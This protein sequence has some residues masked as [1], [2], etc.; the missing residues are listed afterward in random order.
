MSNW[1]AGAGAQVAVA[2]GGGSRQPCTCGE[3]RARL[4]CGGGIGCRSARNRRPTA[5]FCYARQRQ[6][7]QQQ[8]RLAGFQQELSCRASRRRKETASSFSFQ[9]HDV[10][11][12][13]GVAR[14]NSG[15]RG[16][17]PSSN[18]RRHAPPGVHILPT[19]VPAQVLVRSTFRTSVLH[20]TLKETP[21][22]REC[23]PHH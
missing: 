17:S 11:I 20:E 7:T 19:F 4:R 16:M 2:A 5:A 21:P 8:Q 13:S 9:Q 23:K 22:R 14:N 1:C 3:S 18:I 6:D 12:H 10:V 15:T